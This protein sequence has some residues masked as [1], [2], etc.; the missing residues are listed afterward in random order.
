MIEH[1][2]ANEYA[3][4]VFHVKTCLP[5]YLLIANVA[6]EVVHFTVRHGNR[7]WVPLD[8][9]PQLL[10]TEGVFL[11]FYFHSHGWKA[12]AF[13]TS[14]GVFLRHPAAQRGTV[15]N[16]GITLAWVFFV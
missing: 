6:V 3:S 5:T 9:F 4:E 1:H 10:P 2:Q 11:P 13:V 7:Q 14:N 12:Q 15:I 16:T 8:C